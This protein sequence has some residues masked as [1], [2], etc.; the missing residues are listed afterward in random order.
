MKIKKKSF[1]ILLS[2]LLVGLIIACVPVCFAGCGDKNK[3]FVGSYKMTYCD[4][5]G[6]KEYID[7]DIITER[8]FELT[9]N[10]DGTFSL[11]KKYDAPYE[12]EGWTAIGNY[13]TITENKKITMICFMETTT[14]ISGSIK[15]ENSKP[16]FSLT[17]DDNGKLLA[18]PSYS[19][20][21]YS[22]FGEGIQLVVFEKF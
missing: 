2:A 6:Y 10:K 4:I 21:Y 7:D 19:S 14:Y 11:T 9:I 17:F 20:Q 3:Q 22:A 16:Y 13:T 8:T 5:K 18:T 15:G 1:S 12:S